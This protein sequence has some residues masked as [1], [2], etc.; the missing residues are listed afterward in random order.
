MRVA[1]FG[2]ILEHK[3]VNDLHRALVAEG[4]TV[5]STGPVWSGHMFPPITPIPEAIDTAI[6]Q[7]N[8]FKPDLI[9]VIRQSALRPSQIKRLRTTGAKIF[10][11]LPD[12]PV[13]YRVYAQTINEYDLSLHCGGKPILQFYDRHGHKPG[14]RFPFWADNTRIPFVGSQATGPVSAAFFGLLTGRIKADRGTILLSLKDS[15]PGGITVYGRGDIP[16]GLTEGGYLNGEAQMAAA[17]SQHHVILNVPQV[18]S[19]YME[20]RWAQPEFPKLGHFEI[21]SRLVQMAALGLPTLTVAPRSIMNNFSA[22]GPLTHQ[23]VSKAGAKLNRYSKKL[24][25]HTYRQKA[26]LSLRTTFEAGFTSQLRA[27]YLLHLYND[28]NCTNTLQ[29]R[30]YGYRNPHHK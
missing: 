14:V 28:P 17:L 10:V 13:L 2:E 16:E 24:A 15:F 6:I 26:G 7:V 27:Q 20:T 4:A 21:T 5:F 22:L 29:K 25:D 30:R 18:F 3:V 8:D 1:L 9:L 11:W 19:T 23:Q 12:D